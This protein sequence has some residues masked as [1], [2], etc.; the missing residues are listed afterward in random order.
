MSNDLIEMIGNDSPAGHIRLRLDLE[1]PHEQAMQILQI[2]QA[3]KD[4]RQKEIKA[5]ERQEKAEREKAEAA[6]RK[7]AKS[8]AEKAKKT[9]SAKTDGTGSSQ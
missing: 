1:L 2:V 6:A 8:E 4:R 9:E 5:R 3:F 7:A